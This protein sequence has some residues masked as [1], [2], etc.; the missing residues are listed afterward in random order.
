MKNSLKINKKIWY[1]SIMILMLVFVST[2]IAVVSPAQAEKS[3]S[4]TAISNYLA[5]QANPSL[6]DTQK[7]KAAINA[8]FTARYEGQKTLNAEN[9]SA[10]VSTQNGAQE[11]LRK[12]KDRQEIE[13]FQGKTLGLNYLSYKYTLVYQVVKINANTASVTLFENNQVIYAVSAPIVTEMANLKHILSFERGPSGAWKITSDSYRDE[14]TQL[15]EHTSK[16]QIEQN[17]Q[18]EHDFA[19]N[20]TLNNLVV[21]A[22]SKYNSANAVAYAK[23][24]WSFPGNASNYLP[25]YNH[26][27]QRPDLA[28]GGDCTNYASQVIKAGGGVQDTSGTKKWFYS[29]GAKPDNFN[30]WSTYSDDT[31]SRSWAYIGNDPPN[32]YDYLLDTTTDTSGPSA[33]VYAPSSLCNM[34]GGDLIQ[35]SSDGGSSYFHVVVVISVGSGC[36][37]DGHNVLIS[38]HNVD[39]INYP[40]IAYSGYTKRL[41]AISQP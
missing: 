41:L 22:A 4:Q 11:W 15:M 28:Y 27:P 17:I 30:D 19:K 26:P 20:S 7:I 35:L 36:T 13:I 18:A 33:Y 14:L 39:R 25:M 34:A 37:L 23:K 1:V 10:L 8:Y 24:W 12:E 29:A 9:Y 5:A 3:V 31:R 32:L 16:A 2:F 6:S 40:V 38:G 21:R